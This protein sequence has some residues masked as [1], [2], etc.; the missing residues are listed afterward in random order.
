MVVGI[1]RGIVAFIVTAVLGGICLVFGFSPDEWIAAVITQPPQWL[2][3]PVARVAGFVFGG[4][5]GFL[6]WKLWP[7]RSARLTRDASHRDVWLSDAM[8]YMLRGR[9]GDRI[10]LTNISKKELSRFYEIEKEFRQAAL[11]GTLP[12]WGKRAAYRL[13][14]EV[15]AKDW[16]YYEIRESDLLK[17][18][19]DPEKLMVFREG[20]RFPTQEWVRVMTSK[21]KVEELWPAA[22]I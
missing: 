4:L 9:W 13:W 3:H 11:D 16:A 7:W 6:A 22:N 18:L 12:I 5:F 19:A 10:D 1:M 20:D 8:I 2:L 17:S 14:E 15:L 21:A